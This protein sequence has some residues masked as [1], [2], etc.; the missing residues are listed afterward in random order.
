MNYMV[1]CNNDIEPHNMTANS[2]AEA[3][4]KWL[5]KRD[6]GLTKDKFVVNITKT[7][8]QNAEYCVVNTNRG[9]KNYYKIHIDM[10]SFSLYVFRGMPEMK[11]THR[12]KKMV[13]GL[14]IT[15]PKR[16]FL[17]QSI[18]PTD[19]LKFHIEPKKEYK[20][21][22]I[23]QSGKV[24]AKLDFGVYKTGDII[25][26]FEKSYAEL[27]KAATTINGRDFGTVLVRLDQGYVVMDLDK[28]DGFIRYAKAVLVPQK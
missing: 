18:A 17:I 22:R 9:I 11:I 12:Q 3:L 21:I 1:F 5:R 16:D 19:A 4:E 24:V 7:D 15:D 25:L 20:G 10:L 6:K 27:K 8:K 2:P 23:V 14:G 26:S 28:S 13:K